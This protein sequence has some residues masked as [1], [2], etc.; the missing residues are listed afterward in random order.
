MDFVSY[1]EK[2]EHIRKNEMMTLQE[3]C[4]EMDISYLT[5]RKMKNDPESCS[6]KT[7]KRIKKFVDLWESSKINKVEFDTAL[8]SLVEE[9][10]SLNKII[11]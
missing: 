9:I 4:R 5:F 11:N 10:D 7:I 2:I 1:L 8:K 6:F 3:L